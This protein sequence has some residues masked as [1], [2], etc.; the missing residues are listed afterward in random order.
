M[1][2]V[3]ATAKE[4]FGGVAVGFDFRFDLHSDSESITVPAPRLVE[5]HPFATMV[6]ILGDHPLRDEFLEILGYGRE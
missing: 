4:G 5:L 3:E 1:A 6:G 2:L